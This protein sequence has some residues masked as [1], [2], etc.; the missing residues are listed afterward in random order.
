MALPAVVAAVPPREDD[1]RGWLGPSP[2]IDLEDPKLRLRVHALVQL[3]QSDREKALALY[4]FVKRIPIARRMKLRLSTARRVL[5]AGCGDAPDKAT[6]LV[7]MLRI[8]R[9]PARVRYIAV[10]AEMLRGL[11][12]CTRVPERLVVEAWIVDGWQQTDTYIYDASTMAA[13]RQRLK[14]R[15]W[16]WG[17][18]I[19]VEGRMLWDGQV[20]CWMAGRLD[21]DHPMVLRDLGVFHDPLDYRRSPALRGRRRPLLRAVQ[22]NLEAPLMDR[23]LRGLR[24]EGS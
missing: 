4:A 9:I 6:L 12:A 19:H 1:P 16:T 5:D 23:A 21:A 2:L 14:E 3:C 10:R 8:A 11:A 20:S 24:A 22:R 18:G 7:A 17:Y 13:A 15:G